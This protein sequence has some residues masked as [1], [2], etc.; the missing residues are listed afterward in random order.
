MKHTCPI[1]GT[2][3]PNARK[4]CISCG[5][6]LDDGTPY[7]G[8]EIFV[9]PR[10]YNFA[11]IVPLANAVI[12]FIIIAVKQGYYELW[13]NILVSLICALSFIFPIQIYK[14]YSFRAVGFKRAVPDDFD[15]PEKSSIKFQTICC[16]VIIALSVIANLLTAIGIF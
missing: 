5:R 6:E 12:S 2:V 8:A 11:A 1:C 7:K 15:R 4:T 9:K 3:Q 13:M 16:L 14:I 10:W